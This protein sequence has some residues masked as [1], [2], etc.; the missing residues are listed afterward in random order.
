MFVT[1]MSSATTTDMCQ[2]CIP[3]D[4]HWGQGQLKPRVN[5]PRWPSW[6][7][8]SRTQ[9]SPRQTPKSRSSNS[10]MSNHI[11]SSQLF[12]FLNSHRLTTGLKMSR[13][14]WYIRPVPSVHSRCFWCQ[15][16]VSTRFAL[17]LFLRLPLVPERVYKTIICCVSS[18]LLLVKHWWFSDRTCH[19]LVPVECWVLLIS[20]HVWLHLDP[21]GIPQPPGGSPFS[22]ALCK[23]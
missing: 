3:D 20:H 11:F 10:N 16:S 21:R 6:Q 17:S 12:I 9:V 1:N 5:K 13:T 8:C 14:I 4:Q 2:F 18:V 23:T 19:A 15:V 7:A 22:F